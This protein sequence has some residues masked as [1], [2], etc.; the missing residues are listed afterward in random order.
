MNSPLAMPRDMSVNEACAILGVTAPTI[1]KLLAKG[2]LS[3]YLVGRS[4][5]ITGE[6]IARL[7]SGQPAVRGA[8]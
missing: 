7:R 6:S 8:A 1:Y 3:G 5:R 2:E 4:R